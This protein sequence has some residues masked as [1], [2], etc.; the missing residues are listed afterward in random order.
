MLDIPEAFETERL[1]VRAPRWGDGAMVRAAVVES[2][3]ELRPWM[4]WAQ[5]PPS[6]EQSEESVRRSRVRFLERSDLRL[7][8]LDRAT[9]AFVGG[10]GLHRIDW[11]LRSF[12]IGYWVRTSFAGRGYISEAV[13]GI[14][15]FAV[16]QLAAN[17]IDIKCDTR[18]V[19]SRRVAERQGFTLEG[20]LRYEHRGV[21]GERTDT[22]VYA[23]V[24]WDD[25]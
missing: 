3:E 16:E 11:A 12:E 10:S 23:K 2:L 13:G 20:V 9:G 1:L 4:R 5:E 22:A 8:L 18:N 25:F 6:V 24:R 19:R 14:T 21:D 17:R 15:R 7:Q